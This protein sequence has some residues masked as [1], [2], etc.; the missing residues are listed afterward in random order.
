MIM[1]L[2]RKW[3]SVFGTGHP[4]AL[5]LMVLIE[6]DTRTPDVDEEGTI[7][8]RNCPVAREKGS[9]EWLELF[10]QEPLVSPFKDGHYIYCHPR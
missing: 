2:R 10:S 6:D 8:C 3:V 1:S 5:F 9:D 4:L 7:T